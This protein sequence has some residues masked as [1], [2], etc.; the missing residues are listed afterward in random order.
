[1]S[2]TGK[3]SLCSEVKECSVGSVNKKKNYFSFLSTVVASIL[4]KTRTAKYRFPHKILSYSRGEKSFVMT[5][6]SFVCDII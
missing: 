5:F 1:M 3:A 6:L 2:E 4:S